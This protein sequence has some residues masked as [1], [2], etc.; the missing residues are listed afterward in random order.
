M[1][2]IIVSACVT[3]RKRRIEKSYTE[4]SRNWW[5]NSVCMPCGINAQCTIASN[6]QT[7]QEMDQQ[8][9][10]NQN[11]FKKGVLTAPHNE[12]HRRLNILLSF[13]I[14]SFCFHSM[15]CHAMLYHSIPLNWAAR[16][17]GCFPHFVLYTSTACFRLF[18]FIH[19]LAFQSD[20]L[21]TTE[22]LRHFTN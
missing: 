6:E 8:H 5:I 18:L 7:I 11:K 12:K 22:C 20:S 19:I 4:K 10:P 17:V 21:P 15:P 2:R 9:K 14:V 1:F 3:M 13:A 16:G